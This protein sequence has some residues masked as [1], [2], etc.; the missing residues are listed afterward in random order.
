MRILTEVAD[1][2][3]VNLQFEYDCPSKNQGG[4][5]PI[6]DL[7][8]W[9]EGNRVR[10]TFYKKPCAPERTV[11][12]GTA[13]GARTKRNSVFQEGMRRVRALDQW[14]TKDEVMEQ[15]EVFANILRLSG[16]P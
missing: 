7:Q 12:A 15:L 2:I 11:M 14:A 9:V 10:H 13:L 8:V 4:K 5:V 16:Y 6:L 3:D 1:T